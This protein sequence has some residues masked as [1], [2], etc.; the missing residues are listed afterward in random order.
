MGRGWGMAGGASLYGTLDELL[1]EAARDGGNGHVVVALLQPPL[2]AAWDAYL[3]HRF[4]RL[5][6]AALGAPS[7]STRLGQGSA[8]EHAREEALRALSLEAAREV[9]GEASLSSE[10]RAERRAWAGSLKRNP[11]VCAL[12]DAAPGAGC[13]GAGK[14]ELHAAIRVLRDRT[15]VVPL[16]DSAAASAAVTTVSRYFGWDQPQAGGERFPSDSRNWLGDQPLGASLL[17]GARSPPAW[18]EEAVIGG[19]GG[20]V[21]GS[22]ALDD[23]LH[24]EA[25]RLA[26]EQQRSVVWEEPAEGDLCSVAET[27]GAVREFAASTPVVINKREAFEFDGDG[28]RVF[29][30]PL[31]PPLNRSVALLLRGRSLLGGC[32]VSARALIS[33]RASSPSAATHDFRFNYESKPP[34]DGPGARFTL[35]ESRIRKCCDEAEAARRERGEGPGCGSDGRPLVLWIAIKYRATMRS[36]L[37]LTAVYRNRDT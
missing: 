27:A 20:G 31:Q 30:F 18:L 35:P 1:A 4:P 12:S 17:G 2:Q 33:H 36:R 34:H 29:V 28:S 37:E 25:I 6:S 13:E 16:G 21:A 9:S 22:L 8:N 32:R 26:Y 19:Q 15:L 3:S 10:E 24:R 23:A 7:A 14:V 5:A 11:L